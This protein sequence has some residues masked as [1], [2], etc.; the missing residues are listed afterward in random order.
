[1]EFPRPYTREEVRNQLLNHFAN[2]ISYW[3]G[4]GD[5]NV[6]P[7]KNPRLKM[8]GLVFSILAC[9]DGCTDLPAFDIFPMPS[10]EDKEY[11]QKNGENWYENEGISDFCLHESWHDTLERQK[12]N[13]RTKTDDRLV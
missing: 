3:N 9:L 13:V 7:D 5:S 11:Y 2:L 10:P 6:P 1:M 12:E 4:E 8:E